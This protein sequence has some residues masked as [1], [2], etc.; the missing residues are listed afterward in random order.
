MAVQAEK[1]LTKAGARVKLAE[2]EG[3][4]GWR[5]DVFGAIR[6]GIRWLEAGRARRSE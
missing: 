2:Y 4:H 3:G 1:E 6:D 5:G